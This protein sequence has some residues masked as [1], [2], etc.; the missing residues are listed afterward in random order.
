MAKFF[1][2][3]RAHQPGLVVVYFFIFIASLW[4]QQDQEI[5]YRSVVGRNL[6][7]AIETE[8]PYSSDL[9]LVIPQVP[10]NISII[11]S[12]IGSYQK[13]TITEGRSEYQSFAIF[14]CQIRSSE[15]GIFFIPSIPILREGYTSNLE[16]LT[17][18]AFQWDEYNN[19]YPL[20]LQWREPPSQVF[21]G[22]VV[23]LMLEARYTDNIIFAESINLSP[24]PGALMN[25]VSL[26]GDIVP[27]DLGPNLRVFRYPVESWTFSALEVGALKIP[28]GEVQV[29]SLK[30]EIPA[31]E[32][33]VIPLPEEVKN[34]GAVGVFSRSLQFDK[35]ELR[36]GETLELRIVLQG[37][38]NL[39][40]L[41]MIDPILDGWEIISRHEENL[42]QPDAD[43]GYQGSRQFVYKLR[44]LEA[45]NRL[46]DFE[47]YPYWNSEMQKVDILE[48]QSINIHVIKQPEIIQNDDFS[49]IAPEK[50]SR[51]LDWFYLQNPWIYLLLLPFFILII[52]ISLLKKIKIGPFI[53]LIIIIS[54]F[55]A[56]QNHLSV[57]RNADDYW[58]NKDYNAALDVYK[59]LYEPMKF[60][61]FYHY[62]LGLLYWK[63]D[64]RGMA[65]YELRNALNIRSGDSR[66]VN[67]LAQMDQIMGLNDQFQGGLFIN[68]LPFLITLF[69]SSI[70]LT[71]FFIY[72]LMKN[73]TKSLLL[74]CGMLG[75]FF[76]SLGSSL[77]LM[78]DHSVKQLVVIEAEASMK[79]ISGNLSR[80][81]ITLPQGSSL[82]VIKELDDYYFIKTG[83]GLEGWV[84][85]SEVK[86]LQGLAHGK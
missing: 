49:L 51:H 72:H 71:L 85:R 50:V 13:E 37:R 19:A 53:F 82:E 42:Y 10:E 56:P 35:D 20:T 27:L 76:L 64:Q 68:Q 12:Y 41:L 74:L 8:I 33:N 86:P 11:S 23:T 83:Y 55:T 28:T 61:S 16:P 15:P 70:L 48:A 75:L 3:Y 21:Q 34:T 45:G 40:N 36:V 67:A 29:Q 79:K 80:Q 6:A 57:L 60:N 17:F 39:P 14:R 1:G 62:N 26:A 78:V 18:M 77:Y 65:Q 63:T 73:S 24:P 31:L 9:E 5:L 7:I 84:S 38:G 81:W 32:I 25:R 4:S 22:E 2:R 30:R 43:S 52:I 59:D 54:S 66:M 47:D 69:L 44:S 58:K 46:I